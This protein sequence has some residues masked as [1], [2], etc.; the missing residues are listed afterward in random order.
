M[1]GGFAE[2]GP[3]AGR[4]CACAIRSSPARSQRRSS[5]SLVAADSGNG[6]SATLDWSRYLFINVDLTVHLHRPLAGEWVCLDAI[7]IPEPSGIGIADTALYDER[8]PIG[9]AVQTLLD[10]RALGMAC[11]AVDRPAVA[12]RSPPAPGGLERLA[13]SCEIREGGIDVDPRAPAR[14]GAGRR[15]DR[16]RSGGGRRRRAAGGGGAAAS[17]GGELR[18]RLRQRRSRSVPAPRGHG[19]QHPRRA[20]QRDRR[21]GAGADPGRRPPDDRGGGRPARRAGGVAG[22]RAR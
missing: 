17:G 15:C 20:H 18:G 2:L 12:R 8:G 14:A 9:R 22:T 1:R 19:H 5:G 4:G 11:R 7:T 16:R 21:A 10:R 3:A 6:V 13:E